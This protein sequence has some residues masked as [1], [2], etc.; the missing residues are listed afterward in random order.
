MS[1]E[2]EFQSCQ[3]IFLSSLAPRKTARGEGKR[4]TAS[5]WLNDGWTIVLML[6]MFYTLWMSINLPFALI[7]VT[8]PLAAILP[9]GSVIKAPW[10]CC[11]WV[12]IRCQ[13]EIHKPSWL[14]CNT[15]W[16]HP[17][18]VW[19]MWFIESQHHRLKVAWGGKLIDMYAYCMQTAL[20]WVSVLRF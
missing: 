2:S 14:I 9:Q 13:C 18:C 11:K 7:E 6:S 8:V 20:K 17:L 12:L 3:T 19:L 16:L 1:N 15:T 5:L 10:S 4:D